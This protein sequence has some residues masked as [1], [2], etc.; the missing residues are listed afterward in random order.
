MQNDGTDD[1]DIAKDASRDAIKEQDALDKEFLSELLSIALHSD[2]S[3]S[4]PY[5]FRPCNLR[6]TFACAFG[7]TDVNQILLVFVCACGRVT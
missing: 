3:G 7:L 6:C 4:A 5:P 2:P 1:D